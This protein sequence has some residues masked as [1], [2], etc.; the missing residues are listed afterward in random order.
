MEAIRN[1]VKKEP[2]MIVAVALA[3]LNTV[4]T[5]SAEQALSAQVIVENVMLLIAGGTVRQSVYSPATVEKMG[6]ER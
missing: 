3:I 1:F 6:L 4:F 5:L 2:A